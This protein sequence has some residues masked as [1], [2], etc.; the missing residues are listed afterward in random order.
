MIA[1]NRWF[2][3]PPSR[4][5]AALEGQGFR[6]SR[7]WR[8]RRLPRPA[9]APRAVGGDGFGW[10]GFDGGHPPAVG[11]ITDVGCAFAFTGLLVHPHVRHRDVA[12]LR[13]PLISNRQASPGV[14]LADRAEKAILASL[15]F[16]RRKG[17]GNVCGPAAG[18]L[19]LVLVLPSRVHTAPRTSGLDRLDWTGWS[20]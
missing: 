12:R 10:P 18:T 6:S 5:G 2:W 4:C 9:P 11:R 15:R 13:E 8:H 17:V 3:L 20:P 7:G 14:I 19:F 1:E 16:R